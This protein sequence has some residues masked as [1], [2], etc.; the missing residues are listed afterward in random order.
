MGGC[1]FKSIG[2]LVGGGFVFNGG[3]VD[4]FFKTSLLLTSPMAL[5]LFCCGPLSSSL[6]LSSLSLSLS[7][8]ASLFF[9]LATFSSIEVS[10]PPLESDFE[11]V[12][13]GIFKSVGLTVEGGFS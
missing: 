8:S 7:L 4:A 12:F 2:V 3:F 5:F 1:F 13:E 10:N 11:G 9:L 6:Q